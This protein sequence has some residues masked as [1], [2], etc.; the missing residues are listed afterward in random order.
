MPAV[1]LAKQFKQVILNSS[2]FSW[3]KGFWILPF[4]I[5]LSWNIGSVAA[6]GIKAN[7]KIDIYEKAVNNEIIIKK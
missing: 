3:I 1:S 6:M 4:K 5:K 7:N 2:Q